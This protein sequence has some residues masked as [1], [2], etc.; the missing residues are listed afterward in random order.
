[1]PMNAEHELKELFLESAKG[2]GAT[3]E[4][5]E[6]SP[7][8]LYASLQTAI[9]G[10]EAVL[11]A[12]PD[13]LSHALFDVFLK[14]SRVIVKPTKEEL[15]TVRTGVTDAFCAVAATGSV[16]VAVSNNLGSPVSL[17]TR[18]HIVVVDAA[19]IVRRPR[20]VFSDEFA[21][22]RKFARSFSF[23]TGPSATADMGPLV[24]GVH[25][26]GQLH[27]IVLE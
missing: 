2:T 23:I 1:M 17:L 13:Y 27:I 9:S 18:R 19:S 22:A 12:E 21:A 4:T 26:P 15:S 14:D 3:V 10:E 20:D 8:G 16:C 5:A 6:R 7:E 25:G 11:F 24:I